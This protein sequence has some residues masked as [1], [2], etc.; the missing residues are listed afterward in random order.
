MTWLCI[1]SHH[2]ALP[3]ALSFTF[4]N[5]GGIEALGGSDACRVAEYGGC[6][7]SIIRLVRAAL[8]HKGVSCFSFLR[9]SARQPPTGIVCPPSCHLS[10]NS[11]SLSPTSPREFAARPFKADESS[12]ICSGGFFLV[13]A[14]IPSVARYTV[15]Y[16]HFT[17]AIFDHGWSVALIG[18]SEYHPSYLSPSHAACYLLFGCRPDLEQ[19]GQ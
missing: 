1:A 5:P 12:C 11:C 9:A 15:Q 19:S 6:H 14:L 18:P 17:I 16:T 10:S 3:L 13:C 8:E 7:G 4:L 2:L